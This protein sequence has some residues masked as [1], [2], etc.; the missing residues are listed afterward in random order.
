MAGNRSDDRGSRAGWAHH[1]HAGLGVHH[2]TRAKSC[3][4][5]SSYSMSLSRSTFV[6]RQTATLTIGMNVAAGCTILPSLFFVAYDPGD[7]GGC[8]G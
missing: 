6:W 8:P 7:I 2:R 3:M 1:R 5:N 4:S